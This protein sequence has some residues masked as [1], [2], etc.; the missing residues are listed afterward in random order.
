M[1]LHQ[2]KSIFFPLVYC[3]SPLHHNL[4]VKGQVDANLVFYLG[5]NT[6]R[7]ITPEDEES[8]CLYP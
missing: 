4:L 5:L 8:S 2:I 7:N 3:L 1:G 6:W